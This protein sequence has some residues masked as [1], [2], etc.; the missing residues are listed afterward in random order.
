MNAHTTTISEIQK[1]KH[2][3]ATEKRIKDIRQEIL[4]DSEALVDSKRAFVTET[5]GGDQPVKSSSKKSVEQKK[6]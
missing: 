4:D 5:E 3:G 1:R 6:T 2:P